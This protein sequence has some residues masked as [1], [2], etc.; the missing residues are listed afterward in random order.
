MY[1]ISIRRKEDKAIR[2]ILQTT[3]KTLYGSTRFES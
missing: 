1:K 3:K 2:A